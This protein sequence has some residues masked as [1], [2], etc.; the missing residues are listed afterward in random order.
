[1]DCK[2]TLRY[3]D[4][5]IDYEKIGYA[6]REAFNLERMFHLARILG[7]PQNT[8]PSIHIAGTKGKGSIA[9][10][11]SS[12]LKEAGFKTGTYTS[13]HQISPR[14]RIKINGEIIGENDLAFHA[15]EIREKL[16]KENL[17]FLP[18]Y[19]EIFT[20]LAFNYF[21]E[22][23]IDYAV[24]EAGLGGRL[25]ATNIVRPLVAAISPVSYDHTHIL[26]VT[27]Q[28]IAFEK[29]GIIK[30]NCVCVS[31]PQNDKV[32]EV[33][34][35]KCE[36]SKSRLILVGKDIGFKE[37]HH[38]PAGEIFN[39]RG[40]LKDYKFC[41]SHLIGRHQIENAASAIG[42]V[43]ALKKKGAKIEA[44]SIKKGIEKTRNPARCEIISKSPYVVLDGAQNRA[45]AS[46][47]K[48]T[49]K[50]NFNYRR[51]LLVL[52]ISKEKD[53]KGV[54]DELIPLADTVILTKA[55]V[56]RAEEPRAI[57]KFIKGKPVI[58][59][60]SVPEALEKTRM[61]SGRD[62]MMLVTGSFFVTGEAREAKFAKEKLAV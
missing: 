33:I 52:G 53:I 60:D 29:S 54:T 26:G 46:A 13:P 22:K 18:T 55:K 43:E 17:S 58:L 51:L 56:E 32:L 48:E 37:I 1:M 2:E 21:K 9:A 8:F 34:R 36:S 39:L 45:S 4:S 41:V 27:L 7:N 19:F 14:E 20:M 30:K 57:E 50:R 61:L 62:D 5:F 6:S 16:E 40:M 47:L 35:K 59:T 49:V 15:G 24:V 31:A 11:T 12:I 38:G 44:E 3:L 25:D 10:F 23:K 42:I 28:K